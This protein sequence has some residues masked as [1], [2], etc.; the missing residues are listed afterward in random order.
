MADCI[1]L[2]TDT[3][4]FFSEGGFSVSIAGRPWLSVGIDECHEMLINKDCKLAVVHPTEEFVSRVS[5]YFPFRSKV[6]HSLKK[7]GS[8]KNKADGSPVSQSLAKNKRKRSC[9][10]EGN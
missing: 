10:D 5:L 3:Y 6:L 7:K 1:P 8:L 2:P 4:P 9:N